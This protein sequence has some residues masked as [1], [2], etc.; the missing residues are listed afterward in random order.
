MVEW[1]LPEG[2]YELADHCLEN[3]TNLLV[4]LNAWLYSGQEEHDGLIVEERENEDEKGEGSQDGPDRSTIDF[5]AARLWPLWRKDARNSYAPTT[6]SSGSAGDEQ[7]GIKQEN[8]LHTHET[9]VIVCNRTG[10]ENGRLLPQ[11]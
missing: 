11:F 9:S 8:G 4:L 10:E 7:S 6:Q 1:T 2:P 3:R 5:W